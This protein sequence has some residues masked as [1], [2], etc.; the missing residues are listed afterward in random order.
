MSDTVG[1]GSRS[2][3][4]SGSYLQAPRL[5]RVAGRCGLP[6]DLDVAEAPVQPQVR[7]PAL[8]GEQPQLDDLGRQQPLKRSEQAA[9]QPVPLSIRGDGEP[10]DLG[11]DQRVAD[12]PGPDRRHQPAARV[13]AAHRQHSRVTE[14]CRESRQA[15]AQRRQPQIAVR[16]RLGH[17]RG[18][19]QREHLARVT[20]TKPDDALHA[21]EPASF[22]ASPSATADARP[23]LRN[24]LNRPPPQLTFAGRDPGSRATQ[25]ATTVTTFVHRV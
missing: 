9:A 17:V 12:H 14:L 11:C 19:L 13:T 16:L 25:R 10:T 6:S 3:V 7:L 1:D 4:K 20:D 18:P 15:L 23:P 2:S 8:P 5:C 24:G 22:K 21:E